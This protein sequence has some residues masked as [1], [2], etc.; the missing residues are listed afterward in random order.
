[1]LRR[2]NYNII[3]TVGM[4]GEF[5]DCDLFNVRVQFTPAPNSESRSIQVRAQV[6]RH[7]EDSTDLG[8]LDVV[9]FSFIYLR[10]RTTFVLAGNSNT[11]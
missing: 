4:L 5:F 1:M 8:Q 6:G 11:A 7:D 9:R 3:G 10:K 2:E